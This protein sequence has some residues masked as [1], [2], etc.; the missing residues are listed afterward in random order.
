MKKRVLLFLL[1]PLMLFAAGKPFAIAKNG[2]AQCV[3]ALAESANKFDKMAAQDLQKYLGAITGAKFEIVSEKQVKGKAIY[4]GETLPA[5]KFKPFK[6]EEWCI[7]S[8]DGKQLILTGGK[9]IGGFYAVWDFLNELGC[10]ALTFDQDAIP[11]DR[12]LTYIKF[13]YN[14]TYPPDRRRFAWNGL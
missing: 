1:M 6:D 4:V 5:K 3:I 12:N 7:S 2:K 13:P 8:A 10:Y 14:E 11:S 9:R